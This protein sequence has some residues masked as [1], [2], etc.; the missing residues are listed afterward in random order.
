MVIILVGTDGKVQSATVGTTS[1]WVELDVAAIRAVRAA[2]FGPLDKPVWCKV[3][4]I[5]VLR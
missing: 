5:F 2:Q 1:G 4:I 3:P